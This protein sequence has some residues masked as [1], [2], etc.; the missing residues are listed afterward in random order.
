VPTSNGLDIRLSWPFAAQWAAGALVALTAMLLGWNAWQYLPFGARP[1]ELER[2]V[3]LDYRVDLNRASRAELMQLPGV[4]KNLAERILHYREAHGSFRQ[5]NELRKVPGIGPAMMERL[6]PWVWIGSDEDENE[7]AGDQ[8]PTSR[9]KKP[10]GSEDRPPGQRE[11]ALKGLTIN[12]NKASREELQRL[13][14]IGP[15]MSQ[16]IIDEREKRPFAS[17]DEL[18]RVSGIGPKIL[19][20]LRPFVRVH[21]EPAIDRK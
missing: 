3:G 15:K 16:R 17:V 14:G 20:R 10:A 11:A 18:R 12:I 1:T 5:V 9:K 6:R 4:G 2:D 13:P 7:P 8:N 21:D 19:A